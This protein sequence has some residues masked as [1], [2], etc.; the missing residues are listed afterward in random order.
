MRIGMSLLNVAHDISASNFRPLER[1]VTRN[2][3]QLPP[4]KAKTVGSMMHNT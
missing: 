2:R 4:E 3:R 1:Q